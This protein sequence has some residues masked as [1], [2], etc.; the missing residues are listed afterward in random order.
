MPKKGF[1][2]LRRVGLPP[3]LTVRRISSCR[4][5]VLEAVASLHDKDASCLFME[6]VVKFVPPR[7]EGPN[8]NDAL[9]ARW[10]HF[11]HSQRHAFKF[12]RCRIEIPHSQRQREIGGGVRLRRL[13]TMAGDRDLNGSCLLGTGSVIGGQ[14]CSCQ[15]QHGDYRSEQRDIR[16]HNAPLLV[17]AT[18]HRQIEPARQTTRCRRQALRIRTQKASVR[19]CGRNRSDQRRLA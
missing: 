13:K 9:T 3:W 15:Y 2:P 18:G 19:G 12:H 6:I 10:N 4:G 16:S 1:R 8:V 5:G 11:F 17:A 7:C 14:D